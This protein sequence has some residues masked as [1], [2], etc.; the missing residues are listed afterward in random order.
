MKQ[1]L[2][3]KELSYSRILEIAIETSY[4]LLIFLVPIWFA[5]LF[6]IFNMFEFSKLI[7]FRFLVWFLFILTILW[8]VNKGT[9]KKIFFSA[10]GKDL[11]KIGRLFWPPLFLIL[12]LALILPFSINVGQ[13]FFGSYTRQQG[14]SSFLMYFL[15]SFLLFINLVSIKKIKGQIEFNLKLKRIIITAVL[16][17]MLVAI[18]GILQIMNIDFLSWPE[19]PFMTGRAISSLGQP[20]FLASF[21]LLVIPLSFYLFYI[22]S[23]FLVRF[24]YFLTGMLQIIC[25]F[26]TSS[27][28]GVVALFVMLGIFFLGIFLFSH[29]KK[30]I[31]IVIIIS[32]IVIAVS[33]LGTL[34]FFNSGRIRD[35]F[36]VN[37]GSLAARVYFFQAASDAILKRPIFGYGLETG[38]EVFIK[39]Y[40]RDWGLYGNV[41]ANTDRAHNLILDI[42]VTTGFFGLVLF[43]LWYYSFFRLGFKEARQGE[44]KYLSLALFLGSLAYFISLLFSFIIVV[45]EVYFWLFFAVL[46]AIS[47]TTQFEKKEITSFNKKEKIF[48]NLLAFILIALSL[49]PLRANFKA[50]L[51]DY[52]QN[53]MQIVLNRKEFVRAGGLLQNIL[54]LRPNKVQ[55]E[56][57]N[58]FLGTHLTNYCNYD[59]WRD[60]SEKKMITDRLKSVLTSLPDKGY[61]NLF[62][63]AKIY[64]C[65]GNNEEANNYFSQVASITP[66]W[67]FNYLE[68]GRHFVRENDLVSAEK[69]FQLVDINLPDLNNNLI[70]EEH[71]QEVRS[72]K[73]IIYTS[74]GEGYMENGNYQR[75]NVFF[76]AAHENRFWDHS[77]FKKIADCYYLQG[78]LVSAIKY[79]WRGAQASP[80]DYNW[81][82]AL[83]VLYYE[84]GDEQEAILNLETA[85]DLAPDN[86]KSEIEN[87]S[88]YYQKDN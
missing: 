2:F 75:A 48:I 22:S 72:Y 40:E 14:L 52:Y 8:L 24:F 13:S 74:L 29:L 30:K 34:E 50:L 82:L 62:L 87:L 51:A 59:S 83:A 55:M 64:S 26:F 44:N 47:F 33:G 21:L 76:Q 85:L 18:Y 86:K 70:N 77:L 60:L 68:W 38:N 9:I 49:L 80:K 11:K 88:Q 45:G 46:A 43:S 17:G 4:L 6:P 35:S 69:Y 71:K 23:R 54:D 73:Y 57:A 39:Y 32:F 58:S 19:E 36:D 31:K 67:P 27:R 20:N 12:G 10:K 81:Y 5:Y 7:L 63:K 79:N 16:S 53:S 41:S 3:F 42:L 28:G 78:D 37:K 65:L 56:K 15:W 25:L 61:Q 1:K 84:S 66:D